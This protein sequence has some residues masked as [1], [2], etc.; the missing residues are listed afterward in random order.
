MS[1]VNTQRL[2]FHVSGYFHFRIQ[3]PQGI[4]DSIRAGAA[5][6]FDHLRTTKPSLPFMTLESKK[7]ARGL[8]KA[9]S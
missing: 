8:N 1:A 4:G 2:G 7:L 9:D 3:G 5:N 6:Y